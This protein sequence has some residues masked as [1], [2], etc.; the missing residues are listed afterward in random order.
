MTIGFVLSRLV[1]VFAAM[2]AGFILVKTKLL[3]ASAG[4]VLSRIIVYVLDPALVLSS[5]LTSD[6]VFTNEQIF[7]FTG[8]ALAC[9]AFLIA[10]SYGVVRLLRV[11]DTEKGLYQFMY[12]FSNIGFF[13]IPVISALYGPN[14]TILITIFIIPFEVLSFTYG[15]T[16]VSGGKYK[17]SAKMLLHPMI[18]A[19]VAAYVLYLLRV[20]PPAVVTDTIEFIGR[21]TS[22]CAMLVVGI[23]I[24]KAP[25]RRVFANARMYGLI[26]IKMI[27]V[28]AL[29]LFVLRRLIPDGENVD[30]LI[31]VAVM[32]MAMPT[33]T[34]TALLA[35]QYGG[36]AEGAACGVFLATISTIVTIPL[37]VWL[38]Q[39]V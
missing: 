1:I 19:S 6:R 9:Y 14:A 34:N 28:P 32:V 25:L 3:E 18:L 4:T 15:I 37:L 16:R 21:A 35:T 20:T 39:T 36:D 30:L 10:T 8:I 7:L 11:K 24:A 23:L 12:I 2:A 22:P 27:L 26:V 13:G 31:A 38:I 29:V 5:A 17:F 33:A